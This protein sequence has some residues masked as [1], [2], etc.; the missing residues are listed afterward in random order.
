MLAAEVMV[1][2][3]CMY[4]SM[5]KF[6]LHVHR[7]IRQLRQG[8]SPFRSAGL[9]VSFVGVSCM[10]NN[11]GTRRREQVYLTEPSCQR[12]AGG[13]ERHQCVVKITA[14]SWSRGTP[15]S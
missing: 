10:L 2:V 8:C 1:A 11:A 3:W 9:E 7:R 6:V 5:T 4:I 15:R 12:I 13:S 14:L